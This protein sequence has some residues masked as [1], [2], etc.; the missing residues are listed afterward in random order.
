MARTLWQMTPTCEGMG[1]PID[2]T[3]RGCKG[4]EAKALRDGM[5]TIDGSP[6]ACQ[7]DDKEKAPD[8]GPRHGDQSRVLPTMC[9]Q[10]NDN[11]VGARPHGTIRYEISEISDHMFSG[12]LA[13]IGGDGIQRGHRWNFSI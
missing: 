7:S 12:V 9:P 8:V 13:D 10:L 4:K 11:N 5:G 2:R 3:G 6:Q 1:A